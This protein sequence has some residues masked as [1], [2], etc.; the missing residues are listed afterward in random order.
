MREHHLCGSI[1]AMKIDRFSPRQIGLWAAFGALV[2]TLLVLVAAVQTSLN[3]RP[4]ML[5]TTDGTSEIYISIDRTAMVFPSTCSTVTW[6]V[7][8]IKEVY[9]LDRGVIGEGTLEVCSG[10]APYLRVILEDGTPRVYTLDHDVLMVQPLAATAGLVAL[11]LWG[12]AAYGLGI[13]RWLASRRNQYIAVILLAVG[14]VS[15]MSLYTRSDYTVVDGMLDPA[16]TM[17]IARDGWLGNPNLIAPWAYRPL[18]PL[19]ARAISDLLRQP[20]ETGFAILS[21]SGMVAL[22]TL[23]YVYARSFGASV[24]AGVIIMLVVWLSY[25]NVR[26]SLADIYRPDSWAYALVVLALLL[27][28]RNQF[29]WCLVICAVGTLVRE[30]VVVPAV[31]L[32]IT[33]LMKMIRERSLRAAGWLVLTGIVMGAVI[34]LP[35]ALIPVVSSAQVF[36]PQHNPQGTVYG[37]YQ[38]L[39]NWPRN[40]E[41]LTAMVMYLLPVLLLITPARLRRVW[42]AVEK[43]RWVLFLYIMLTFLLTMYGGSG[44]YRYISYLFVIQTV[45]LAAWLNDVTWPEVIWMLVVVALCNRLLWTALDPFSSEMLLTEARQPADYLP[46]LLELALYVGVMWSARLINIWITRLRPAVEDGLK[47]T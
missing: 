30:F 25:Y 46:R 20:L 12:L 44:V 32:S 7:S 14:L 33:L 2:L 38:P 19:A 26:F 13:S 40:T 1:R 28:Q 3:P 47:S 15:L 42:K 17:A 9:V 29:G 34:I 10:N 31:L 43:H 16:R 27:L 11:G 39:I 24:R 8:H 18:T 23:V 6:N 35:R 5:Q 21:L 37:L 4:Q 41:L 45:V 36:D 22:L